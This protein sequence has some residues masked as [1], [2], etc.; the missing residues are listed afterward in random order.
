MLSYP[1]N[2]QLK[3]TTNHNDEFYNQVDGDGNF[4][5]AYTFRASHPATWLPFPFAETSDAGDTSSFNN[6]SNG[7][8][9]QGYGQ[10]W[11]SK[12]LSFESRRQDPDGH[13]PSALLMG[14]LGQEVSLSKDTATK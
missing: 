3:R 12:F 9:M 10:Y 8:K 1:V 6:W 7:K 2:I 4:S 13:T 11:I 14:L 5:G